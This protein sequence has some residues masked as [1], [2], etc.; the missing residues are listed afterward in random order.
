M[1]KQFSSMEDR[2]NPFSYTSHRNN[3]NE[4]NETIKFE[5]TQDIRDSD[6][7]NGSEEMD[8]KPQLVFR[9]FK[10]VRFVDE[11]N[12]T[13]RFT[14]NEE[15]KVSS[16]KISDEPILTVLSR[17]LQVQS[18]DRKTSSEKRKNTMSGQD[19]DVDWNNKTSVYEF[20]RA[21]T[22]F[23]KVPTKFKNDHITTRFKNNQTTTIL[24]NDENTK[25]CQDVIQSITESEFDEAKKSYSR[26]KILQLKSEGP[27]DA[28]KF[29]CTRRCSR[30][31]V[32]K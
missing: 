29:E 27:S 18:K 26:L 16:D 13:A 12:E 20:L 15:N 9:N 31:Y 11:L 8:E 3:N 7:E 23:G 19:G 24:T 1:W 30:N 22:N 10:K 25:V 6:Q 17:Q 5:N 32:N 21:K 14:R 28:G 2:L 4:L